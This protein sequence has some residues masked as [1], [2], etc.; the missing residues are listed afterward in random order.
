MALLK[1]NLKEFREKTNMKQ[2][3]LADLVRVR[4]ETIVHLENG[5]YNPSLKLVMHIAKILR[6]RLKTCLNL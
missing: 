6:C 2:R 3:E 5:K 1:T 4:G